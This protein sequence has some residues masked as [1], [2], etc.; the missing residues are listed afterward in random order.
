MTKRGSYD[1]L[2]WA[3]VL[4]VLAFAWASKKKAPLVDAMGNPTGKTTD[5]IPDNP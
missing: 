2:T 1:A 5:A 3:G 4:V